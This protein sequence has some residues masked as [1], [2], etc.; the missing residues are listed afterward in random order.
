MT[1][2]QQKELIMKKDSDEDAA[3]YQAKTLKWE[4]SGWKLNS[5]KS[6]LQQQ[7]IV[8]NLTCCIMKVCLRSIMSTVFP[9]L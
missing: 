3:S 5:H 7:F 9:M 1:L 4:A 6:M 2:T 8:Q